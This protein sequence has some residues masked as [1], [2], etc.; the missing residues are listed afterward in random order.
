MSERCANRSATWHLVSNRVKLFMQQLFER[1]V[2][3]HFHWV[4]AHSGIEGNER[5]DHV[6]SVVRKAQGRTSKRAPAPKVWEIEGGLVEQF[7]MFDARSTSKQQRTH[8]EKKQ[9]FALKRWDRRPERLQKRQELRMKR[10]EMIKRSRHAGPETALREAT[11][12]LSREKS[13][14]TQDQHNEAIQPGE[15]R[16]TEERASG[17]GMQLRRSVRLAASLIVKESGNT[18]A[19][20]IDIID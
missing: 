19:T 15:P 7:A 4:P 1:G 20:A 11:L 5:A 2:V 8:F 6:C 9:L 12:L 18:M 10:H 16:I 3:V 13:L 17:L 14:P